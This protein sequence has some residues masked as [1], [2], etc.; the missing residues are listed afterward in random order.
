MKHETLLFDKTL[1]L[2]V[3]VEETRAGG[4]ILF[5]HPFPSLG[6]LLVW[7]ERKNGAQEKHHLSRVSTKSFIDWGYIILVFKRTGMMILGLP[8]VALV[9]CQLSYSLSFATNYFLQ[10]VTNQIQFS[11]FITT[12][13]S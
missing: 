10:A 7:C 6:V 2:D 8:W 13:I 3:L 11:I 4:G 12:S 1:R 5:K 9:F